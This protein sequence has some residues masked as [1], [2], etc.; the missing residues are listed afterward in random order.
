MGSKNTESSRWSRRRQLLDRIRL[1]LLICAVVASGF[2][3]REALRGPH[4]LGAQLAVRL[5][6]IG[7]ALV[8]FVAL[9]RDWVVRWAW[10]LAVA[11]VALSYFLTALAG[12]L[13]PTQEYVTTAVL[14]VGAAL[15]T[16]TIVPWGLYAQC[17]T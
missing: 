12:F 17:A 3:V 2:A 9:K 1:I 7:L 4:E 8:G 11:I 15:T 6:G 10:T 16:A 14:F 5:F 13:S